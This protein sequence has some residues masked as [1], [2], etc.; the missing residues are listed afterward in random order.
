MYI[1]INILFNEQ[2]IQEMNPI[3][4]IKMLNS[5]LNVCSL[6]ISKNLMK[7]DLKT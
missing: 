1:L 5:S 6:K 2:A 3:V 7:N 4:Y